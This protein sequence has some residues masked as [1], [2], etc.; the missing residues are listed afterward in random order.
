MLTLT[1]ATSNAGPDAW[2]DCGKH[3]W[4]AAEA[5][6]ANVVNRALGDAR[7]RRVDRS[8]FGSRHRTVLFYCP[9][10]P[11]Q[12]LLQS[13]C[14]VRLLGPVHT[15]AGAAQAADSACMGK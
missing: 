10:A 9:A 13:P 14:P 6:N 1:E 4:T 7:H 2:L 11:A 8:S 3:G 5:I 15:R 12:T